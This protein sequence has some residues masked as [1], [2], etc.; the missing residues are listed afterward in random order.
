MTRYNFISTAIFLIV[1]TTCLVYSVI[2]K[3]AAL[4]T[5]QAENNRLR[6]DSVRQAE[7]VSRFS[8]WHYQLDSLDR[9]GIDSV[10]RAEKYKR[11]V[12]HIANSK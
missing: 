1:L 10:I 2:D 6:T 7:L 3:R 4:D 8:K 11:V 12:K 9:K 5:M